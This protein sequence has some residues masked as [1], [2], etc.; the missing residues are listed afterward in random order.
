M[1]KLLV[2]LLFSLL[3]LS[4]PSHAIE[5]DTVQL[6]RDATYRLY[7]R[8]SPPGRKITQTI[9]FCSA[10]FYK[11]PESAPYG[12][13]EGI[14]GT[15]AGHCLDLYSAVRSIM[16]DRVWGLEMELAV[17]PNDDRS[18]FVTVEAHNHGMRSWRNWIN[19]RD[20][21]RRPEPENVEDWGIIRAPKDSGLNQLPLAPNDT[22]DTGEPIYLSGYPFGLGQFWA[23]GTAT[24]PYQLPGTTY[25]GYIGSDFKASPGNSGS[26]VVDDHGNQVG[27]LV[28]GIPG[29]V[30]L[31]TPISVVQWPHDRNRYIT[32]PMND[33]SRYR[34]FSS[35]F[36]NMLTG[37]A[38]FPLDVDKMVEKIESIT[39]SDTE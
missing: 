22:V 9:A 31:I 37:P 36:Y 34:G 28:A 2:G 29:S 18:S 15:T 39:I 38:E 30:S 12:S 16:K 25:D 27:I 6:V 3:F 32:H 24:Y 21:V 4:S 35:E 7:I 20:E 11:I 8:I 13:D 1:K 23:Q 17:S 14:Y 19:N 5:K 10:S 26:P 33:P